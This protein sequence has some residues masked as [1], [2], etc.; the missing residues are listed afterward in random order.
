MASPLRLCM[1]FFLFAEKKTGTAAILV[2]DVEEA[3]GM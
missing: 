1:H 3:N 2:Q